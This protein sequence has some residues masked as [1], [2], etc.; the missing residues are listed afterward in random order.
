MNNKKSLGCDIV[1]DLLELYH[2]KV[3]RE[4]TAAAVK[5]H[6][7]ECEICRK[8]YEKIK[9]ALPSSAESSTKKEFSKL[10]KKKRIKQTV[11]TVICCL[12]TCLILA[13]SYYLLTD[14]CLKE[15][16]DLQVHKVYRYENNGE[17]YFFILYST[18]N[19]SKES[20][21]ADV[22]LENGRTIFSFSKTRPIISKAED[23]EKPLAHITSVGAEKIFSAKGG[24]FEG[25]CDELIWNGE[26][27]W[28]KESNSDDEIPDYVYGYRDFEN[29]NQDEFGNSDEISVGCSVAPDNIDNPDNYI[30]VSYPD[31]TVWWNLKGEVIK[32]VLKESRPSQ[33]PEAE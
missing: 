13:S 20:C 33:V 28:T 23:F 15:I 29:G 31:K 19:G 32:E 26:V 21:K 10:M 16:D 24:L 1:C 25:S 9:E 18:A 17:D 22:T 14:V 8:E 2:D 6:L 12:L 27:I 7:N 11:I 5:E 3:V 30:C 4:T